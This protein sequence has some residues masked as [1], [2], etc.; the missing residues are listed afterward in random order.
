MDLTGSQATAEIF[1]TALKAMARPEREKVMTAIARDKRMWEDMQDLAVF[2]A[3]E[4]ELGTPYE[5][6]ARGRRN[7]R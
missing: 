6:Y 4:P 3:R 1:L 5:D 7:R 2:E